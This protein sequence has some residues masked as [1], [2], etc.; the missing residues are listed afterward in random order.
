M[1]NFVQPTKCFLEYCYVNGVDLVQHVTMARA[2]ET[3]CKPYIT[4]QL[5]ILDTNNTIESMGLVGGE[6]VTFCI[7]TTR[8]RREFNLQIL[9]LNGQTSAKGKRAMAYCIELIGSEY[10]GD[11]TNMVQQAF[12][13]VT[14]TDAVSK[15]YSQFL[16]G[17]IDIKVPSTGLLGKDNS[18]I[19]NSTKPFKAIADFKKV[20]TFA[21]YKTGNI[22]TWR[23]RDGSHLS[24][25]E[26][27][28]ATL[29]AQD[30]FVQKA[31]W[32]ASWQDLAGAEN[33][34]IEASALVNPEG[35]GRSSLKN[36]AS[37]MSGERKVIDFLTNKSLFDTM[38]SSMGGGAGV[39]TSISSLL[40]SI[41]GV[42]G[43]HGGSHNYYLNDS[44]RIPNQSVRETDKEKAYG[45]SI[46]GGPQYTIQVPIQSGLKCVV[47]KGLYAKLLPPV[48]DQ[49]S[50]FM[51]ESQTGGLM[52]IVDAMHE[53]HLDDTTMAGT[54]TFRCARGG[55]S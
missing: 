15:L 35:S 44:S 48:G 18:Y 34:I 6:N 51:R 11:K 29:S 41:K 16:G 4:G 32:G 55:F 17:G 8:S 2:F 24:P 9:S 46:A 19:T 30:S 53:C 49:T 31:T 21:Q 5:N 33:A 54:S 3:L 39:G 20:M 43:G 37:S 38:S 52:L 14:A 36:I 45:A 47:G 28:F 23:D 22:L 12:S 10:Y 13:G 50:P 40:G 1:S 42:V 7:N 26:H 27:L 25:L